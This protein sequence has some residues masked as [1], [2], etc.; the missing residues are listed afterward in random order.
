MVNI[1]MGLERILIKSQ[2]FNTVYFNVWAGNKG[3]VVGLS[4]IVGGIS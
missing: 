3:D 1:V 4:L 2:V